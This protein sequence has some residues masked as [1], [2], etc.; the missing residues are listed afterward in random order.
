MKVLVT[1]GAG[2]IGSELVRQLYNLK[3]KV[4][5]LDSLVTGKKENIPP[6]VTFYHGDI[7]NKEFVFNCFSQ[8]R[9][10][11]I[12]HLAAQVSVPYSVRNTV[13]DS[14]VNIVGTLNILDAAVKFRPKKIIFAS[15]A[16]VYGTPEY[17]PVDENHPVEPLAG[18]GVSKYGAELYIRLYSKLYGLDYTILRYANVYGPGQLP[19]SEAGVVAI[20]INS[21][22][23]GITPTIFGD[24]EQTRDFV[25]V[26]DVAVGNILAMEKGKN[27]TLNIGTGQSTS[28]REL[29]F[30]IAR[31]LGVEIEPKYE[32]RRKQD[33]L[34]SYLDISEAQKYLKWMPIYNLQV[35][36]KETI[37]FFRPAAIYR[38]EKVRII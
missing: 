38:R 27:L 26:K 18:Y 5:V 3:Y 30:F 36:L 29:Y 10:D 8:E 11:I 12:F 37:Y 4:S 28:I 7:C 20:F 22:L 17:L 15:S 35:G 31:E 13:T 2:F 19:D 21:L 23:T 16:A 33:I 6:G 1:G 25:F 32:V 9:P 24:G 14:E 34:H